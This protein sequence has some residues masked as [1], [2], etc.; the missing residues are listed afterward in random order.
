M[1]LQYPQFYK[2]R[3]VIVTLN[4]QL[5]VKSILNWKKRFS[6]EFIFLSLTKLEFKFV[7]TYRNTDYTITLS[8]E[9]LTRLN[10]YIITKWSLDVRN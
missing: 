7:F 8:I 1:S 3:T 4:I 6:H 9:S 2:P 10:F 5:H